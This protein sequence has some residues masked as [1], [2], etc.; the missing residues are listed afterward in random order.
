MKPGNKTVQLENSS[1]L[2]P[3]EGDVVSCMSQTERWRGCGWMEVP[4]HETVIL[5]AI[6]LTSIH[7]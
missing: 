5:T 2:S 1:L 4:C 6:K 3:L 7:Y